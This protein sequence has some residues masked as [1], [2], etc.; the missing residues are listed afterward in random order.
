[1]N[2]PP[3]IEKRVPMSSVQRRLYLQCQLPGGDRAYHLLYVARVRGPFPMAGAQAFAARMMERHESLRTA[4][5]VEDGAFLSEVHKKVGFAFAIVDGKESDLE[6]I[7]ETYDTPFELSLPPLLRV[8]ILRL[9]EADCILIFNCH[10]LIFDGYSAGILAKDLLDELSG[11]GLAPPERAYSDFVEWENRFFQSEAYARQRDF[12]CL[13]YR[14]APKRLA[15]PLDFPPPPTKSF[16]GNY[17]IC[18]L[19]SKGPKAFSLSQ[20]ATL[21]MT[22]LAVFY[23]VLFKLTHQEEITIGTL[24]SPRESGDFQNVIGLFANT[25]PLT[26]CL[27]S[28]TPF[29]TFLQEVR[30]GVFQAMQH[31]DFPFEHLIRQLPFLE[32]GERN[33]LFDVVFNFERVVREKVEAFG[34]VTIEPVDYYAKV[35]MFDLAVDIV[36]YED[37]VRFRIEY[38]TAL[39]REESMKG[40]MDAYFGIIDQVCRQPDI[41]IGDLSLV[42]GEAQGQLRRWNDTARPL[43][44]GRTFLDT[45]KQRAVEHAENPALR[46]NGREVTY[47]QIEERANRLAHTLIDLKIGAGS[48]VAVAMDRSPEWVI[49]L[50]ALWKTGAVY[51]PLAAT[52]PEKRLAYQL[53]DSKAVL[54]ITEDRFRER[55]TGFSPVLTPETL[56]TS[57]TACLESGPEREIDAAQ[58]A[59]IIYTSGSTGMP[60]GVL[61]DHRAVFAHIDALKGIYKLQPDDNV[62]QFSSPTFDASLEQILMTLSGGSCLVLLDA[63]LQDPRSLLDLLVSEEITI[64]EFPPAYLKELLPVLSP[65]AFRKIRRLVSGGDVLTSCLAREITKFLPAE[66]QLLN[67][68][69]PTEAT[70]AATVY[71]VAGNRERY[72]S[73]LSLPIGRPLPNTRIFILDSHDQ[74]LPIGVSGELCIAGDR[75]ARGYLNRDALTEEKFVRREL[76]GTVERVYKTGDRARWLPD[77]NIEFLGRLDRQVQLRGYRIELGEIEQVLQRHPEVRDAIVLK[78]CDDRE[79]LAAFVATSGTDAVGAGGLYEWLKEYLPDYMIP[80]TFTFL[81]AIPRNAEGKVDLQSLTFSVDRGPVSVQEMPLDPLELDLW[82]LW[83]K[84]LKVPQ[85]GRNDVFF[86]IGGNSLSAIQVMVEIKNKYNVEI[87]LSLLLREP[88]IV[89]LADFLRNTGGVPA[90]HDCVVPLNPDGTEPPIVLIPGLGGNVLDLYELSAHLDKRFPCYGLQHSWAG[91]KSEIND[92][93]ETLARYYLRELEALLSLE[94]CILLGHSFGGYVAYEMARILQQ[95]ERPPQS[96]LLLDVAAPQGDPIERSLCLNERDLIRLTVGSL[97]GSRWD[98]PVETPEVSGGQGNEYEKALEV[99]KSANRLPHS[100]SVGQ[101]RQ[102]IETIARR[103]AAFCQYQPA[104]LIN[105]NI[106]LYRALEIDENREFTREDG[107]WADFTSGLFKLQWVPGDHFTM[108]KGGHASALAKEIHRHSLRL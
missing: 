76:L 15:L 71:P 50:L 72:D 27:D 10:H 9:G 60:K 82:H 52:H 5:C 103:A 38:A 101:F 6:E 85:I 94:E 81:D 36:E 3:H 21:F 79:S 65:Y 13:Q 25:L 55:F 78:H 44:Q 89:V 47:G 96:L 42:S 80:S 48:V 106:C 99:L 14:E 69:G 19:D 91:E 12:W 43:K 4:F 46:L 40:L 58:P 97:L 108:I 104:S 39:F 105:V 1:M 87:P 95:R 102:Y 77:G 49:A 98:S 11:R 68:Y 22:L 34:D 41:R 63:Q 66:A 57:L 70:M 51:L 92:C 61:V 18:Y 56:A 7:I 33:P 100:L 74:T 24:V 75:L 32:K 17:F 20:G 62:L 35:S 2:P 88:T 16:A 45:W 37:Q 59:Y 23:C 107:H 30:T 67:F 8:I 84:I 93:I 53:T 28:Q 31:A 73:R 29:S 86:Q 64:A 83:R 90:S 54:V 26:R